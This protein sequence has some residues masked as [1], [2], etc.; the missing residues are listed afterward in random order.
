[1]LKKIGGLGPSEIRPVIWKKVN[2]V[3]LADLR[4]LLTICKEFL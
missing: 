4:F 3:N 1:M 2:R